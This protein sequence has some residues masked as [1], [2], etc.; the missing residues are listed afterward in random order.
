MTGDV[1]DEENRELRSDSR[2][3]AAAVGPLL[4]DDDDAK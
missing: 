3:P 2:C 1:L 4:N